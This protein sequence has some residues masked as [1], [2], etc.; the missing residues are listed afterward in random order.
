MAQ[1]TQFE[2][3]SVN[4]LAGAN[5]QV[6]EYSGLIAGAQEAT[7]ALSRYVERQRQADEA[8]LKVEVD[9]SFREKRAGY[10]TLKGGQ[11]RGVRDDYIASEKVL[12]ADQLSD[13]EDPITR[14]NM[15]IYAA[16]SY[17]ANMEWVTKYQMDQ[18]SVYRAQVMGEVNSGIDKDLSESSTK[19]LIASLELGIAKSTEQFVKIEGP[20]DKATLSNYYQQVTDDYYLRHIQQKFKEDPVGMVKL[21]NERKDYIQSRVSSATFNALL[22]TYERNEGPAEV[23]RIYGEVRAKHGDD[24]LAGAF[25]ISDPKNFK[26]YG[27]EENDYGR[28][29]QVATML[30]NQN[31]MNNAL[32]K[33]Q[34]EERADQK[35]VEYNKRT[36]AIAAE[37][38]VNRRN[39]MYRN[40]VMDIRTDADMDQPDREKRIANLLKANYELNPLK[41]REV[42]SQIDSGRIARNAQIHSNLGDGIGKDTTELENYLKEKKRFDK[43]SGGE[44][45]MENARKLYMIEAT[46]AATAEDRRKGKPVLMKRDIE[47]F[48]LRLEAK[49]R[50]EN[51]TRNNPKILDLYDELS[52]KGA[53]K[54]VR[55]K[56]EYAGEETSMW[57]SDYYK[58]KFQ[59]EPETDVAAEL[60]RMRNQSTVGQQSGSIGQRIDQ[61]VNEK[62][63]FKAQMVNPLL[64]QGETLKEKA[65]NMQ[66]Q[67]E[68]IYGVPMNDEQRIK[69]EQSIARGLE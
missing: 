13:I 68:L 28:A 40:L 35:S 24:Y 39:L 31:A 25:E 9:A 30:R 38:D 50:A 49:R 67:W 51:L 47:R 2:R 37:P 43:I 1:V 5:R 62:A 3:G 23:M 33:Q 66:G 27:I 22:D 63:K 36:A 46:E 15:K 69:L 41:I 53:Y 59:T 26:K 21:W 58:F 54:K 17:E 61:E 7:N 64:I 45:Y 56:E 44:D 10:S 60:E 12:T 6:T 34:K 11:A 8:M 42:K 52:Q 20:Q 65:D 18:D 48:M 4:I 57:I 16:N 19:E 14:Q 32:N 55:G 29:I